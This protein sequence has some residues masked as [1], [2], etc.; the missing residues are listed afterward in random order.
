[1]TKFLARLCW[2]IHR[3]LCYVGIH[4]KEQLLS[5]EDGEWKEYGWFC[6]V[7]QKDWRKNRY[8]L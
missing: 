3:A 5:R 1:V 8:E 7:C 2:C 6:G 4:A